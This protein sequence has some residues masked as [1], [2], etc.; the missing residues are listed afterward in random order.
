M[1]IPNPLT[2]DFAKYIEALERKVD[3]AASQQETNF[4]TLSRLDDRLVGLASSV[5]G[6]VVLP[7]K[8]VGGSASSV[9]FSFS[10]EF[11]L[12]NYLPAGLDG[13]P[14]WLTSSID[15]N[16]EPR[17]F[18]VPNVLNRYAQPP[19][20]FIHHGVAAEFPE[21]FVSPVGLRES[22]GLV[23]FF[24][25]SIIPGTAGVAWYQNP[26]EQLGPVYGLTYIKPD[27]TVSCKTEL[28]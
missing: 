3:K 4:S 21:G 6:I 28:V 23:Y 26:I 9:S 8:I 1:P 13:L 11:A 2:P 22:G 15:E 20:G 27:L 7:A 14:D 17:I 16:D 12:D 24:R 19:D 25:G 5:G 18:N 10:D